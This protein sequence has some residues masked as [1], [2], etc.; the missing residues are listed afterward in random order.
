MPFSEFL[1]ARRADCRALVAELSKQFAYVG[2]LG[3]DIRS[4]RL[5]VDKNTSDI[6]EGGLTECGFVIK[7]HN[8]RAFFEY[9]LDDVVGDKAALAQRIVESVRVAEALRSREIEVPVPHDE[10]LIQSFSRDCDFE[11]YSDE[12]VLETAK[13]VRDEILARDGRIVNAMVRVS[14]Y[15]VSKLFVSQNRELDQ[16][17]SWVNAFCAAI[18]AD[19]EK[20]VMAHEEAY[21]NCT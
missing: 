18:L 14:P 9:S 6:G 13:R 7:M 21:S 1:E 11:E 2:I 3:S 17:Y 15:T 16:F 19:G 8:G 5:G 12:A 10:H 4:T 20:M